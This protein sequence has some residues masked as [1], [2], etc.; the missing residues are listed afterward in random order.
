MCYDC[1]ILCAIKATNPTKTD[2]YIEFEN[3]YD[4]GNNFQDI[5]VGGSA[6]FAMPTTDSSVQLKFV[7]N[8]KADIKFDFVLEYGSI[9]VKI[10]MN[11][12]SFE[13]YDV[14]WSS[15][16]ADHQLTIN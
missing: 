13:D 15:S 16:G 9:D 11:P 12:Y 4:N 6:Y 14:L 1:W 2:I 5:V 3:I 7:L 8:S 10:S